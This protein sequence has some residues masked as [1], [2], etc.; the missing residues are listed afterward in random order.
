ML[1]VRMNACETVDIRSHEAYV[2]ICWA[3][4]SIAIARTV[5]RDS[6]VTSKC[7]PGN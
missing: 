6:N 1:V 2:T 3:S 7:L 4:G 5:M